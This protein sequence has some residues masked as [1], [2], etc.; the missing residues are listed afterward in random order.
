MTPD[1]QTKLPAP[2]ELHTEGARAELDR[3]C[4]AQGVECSAPRTAARLLDKLVGEYLEEA[5]ISPTFICD[6]PQGINVQFAMEK[7]YFQ[8]C[9]H[10]QNGTEMFPV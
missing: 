4:V 6:H 3:I 10:W 9:P 5:S 1:F 8:L 2:T 7:L